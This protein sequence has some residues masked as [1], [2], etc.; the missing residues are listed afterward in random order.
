M[1][2]PRVC[3]RTM[4]NWAPM[5]FKRECFSLN[6]SAA[7]RRH[8]VSP[9]REG[10]AAEKFNLTTVFRRGNVKRFVLAVFLI[11]AVVGPALA[12]SQKIADLIQAGNRKA[13]LDRI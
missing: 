11:T 13:A 8:S 5:S 6:F 3:G 2:R 9:R 4:T 1:T 7:E 10:L 12:Q